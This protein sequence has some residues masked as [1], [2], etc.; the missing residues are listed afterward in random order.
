MIPDRTAAYSPQRWRLVKVREPNQG[1]RTF[2][3]P[4]IPGRP[5][6][7]FLVLSNPTPHKR[8][9]VRPRTSG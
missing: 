7:P 1:T 5:V 8:Y 3:K 2:L 6:Y 9:R 4:V